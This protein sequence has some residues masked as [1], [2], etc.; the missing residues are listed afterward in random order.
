MMVETKSGD[1]LIKRPTI[2]DQEE[3]FSSAARLSFSLNE[4]IT[5]SLGTIKVL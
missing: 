3:S 1:E 2:S 4:Q 5:A